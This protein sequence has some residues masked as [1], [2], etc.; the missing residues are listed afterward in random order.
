LNKSMPKK[1]MRLVK[2]H[3]PIGKTPKF[4][5]VLNKNLY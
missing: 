3:L 1:L 4:L 2:K 5:L